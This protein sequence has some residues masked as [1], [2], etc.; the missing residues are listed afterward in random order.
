M[1]KYMEKMLPDGP[2]G[3]LE[4]VSLVDRANVVSGD[5]DEQAALFFSKDGVT[6]GVWECGAY[7]ERI[8]NRPVEEMCVVISGEVTLSTDDGAS[9][10]YGPGDSFLFRRG[11]TG[12]WE[13]KDRFR[14]YFFSTS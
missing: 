10:T 13:T 5:P 1:A 14:K 7:K 11:F 9:E 6:A 8:E 2:K 4:N 12:Y 3:E